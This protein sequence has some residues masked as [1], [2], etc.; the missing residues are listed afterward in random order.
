M[1]GTVVLMFYVWSVSEHQSCDI[2]AR[3]VLLLIS[4]LQPG[5]F[6]PSYVHSPDWMSSLPFQITTVFRSDVLKR[7]CM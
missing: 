7:E 4:T 6:L 5:L 2:F 3:H 1:P